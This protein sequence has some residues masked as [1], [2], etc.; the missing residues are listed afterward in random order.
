MILDVTERTQKVNPE[1]KVKEVTFNI[2]GCSTSVRLK[3]SVFYK[4][5]ESVLRLV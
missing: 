4:Y 5:D 3:A 1:S 2:L